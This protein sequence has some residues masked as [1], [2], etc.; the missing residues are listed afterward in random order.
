[1]PCTDD[2]AV[3]AD[4]DPK[5]YEESSSYYISLK[6]KEKVV[7]LAE[8]HPKW[9]LATL[10]RNGCHRLK[11][12][13]LLQRWKKDILKG[14]TRIDKLRAIDSETFDR[15]TEARCCLEQVTTRMLQQWVM[16]AVFPFLS[17]I[18]DFRF[19]ASYTWVNA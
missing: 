4:Y 15:F 7:A 2:P 19:Q 12:K 6:Y 14:G 11:R 1:M 10:Q 13:D 9:S 16:A 18:D 5:D 17:M 8:A 3:D